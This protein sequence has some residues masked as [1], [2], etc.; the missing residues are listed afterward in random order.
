MVDNNPDPPSIEP[1]SNK[2]NLPRLA[3]Y[4][5]F[6]AL[7]A[8]SLTVIYMA[9]SGKTGFVGNLNEYNAARG[10]ITFLIA[11]TTVS[12]AVILVLASIISSGNSDDLKMRFEQ[13]REIFTTLIGILGTIVGFYF[14]ATQGTQQQGAPGGAS[15]TPTPTPTS[16][17][18]SSGQFTTARVSKLNPKAGETVTITSFVAT[19]TPPYTYSITFEPSVI[20]AIRDATS[21]DGLI[22]Q[23]VP[24]PLSVATETPVNFRIDVNDSQGQT[25]SYD[26]DGTQ[27]LRIASQ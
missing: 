4:I 15:P 21:K 24:I 7:A 5:L 18:Q 2:W 25:V 17:I 6:T 20:P 22:R 14:G 1:S 27:K 10:L 13:G 12:L 16:T 9:I 19:G 3:Q 11:F 8:G 26:G 23:D